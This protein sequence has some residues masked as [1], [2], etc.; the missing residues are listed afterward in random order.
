MQ[1]TVYDELEK[2]YFN[3]EPVYKEFKIKYLISKKMK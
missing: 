3:R 1:F 2:D